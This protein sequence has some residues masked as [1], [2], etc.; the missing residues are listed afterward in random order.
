MTIKTLLASA[1]NDP[2]RDARLD[3][4]CDLAAAFHARLLG[5]GACALEP[6]PADPFWTGAMTGELLSLYH[7]MAE[8]DVSEARKG[9][10]T[11]AAARAIETG[12]IGMIDH[13][14]A[15]LNAAARA[16]DLVI[17]AAP[18]D[19][20]PFRG[21]DPV[22]VIT[23]AGRPVLVVPA[24]PL[25]SPLGRTAVIAWKDTRESRLAAAA[26]LPLLK[27]TSRTHVLAVCSE[28]QAEIVS[29]QITD[30][31]AWLTRHGVR[32]SP[33]ILLRNEIGTARRLLD[34]AVALE[35]GLI[36]AGAYGHLRLTEWILGGV[37]QS[38]L[39]DSSLSLLMAR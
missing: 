21:P 10:D 15:V 38:L 31:A 37:T 34:R 26:A 18:N 20:T 33:E 11:V 1:S 7:D 25:A 36:V 13:P 32:A 14:A 5:V 19:S 23:G 6:V 16:A 28:A 35:A 39:A 8:N 22:E 27:K 17:V 30:V 9:F 24:A 4:A 12:W 2:G 3:L 29:V